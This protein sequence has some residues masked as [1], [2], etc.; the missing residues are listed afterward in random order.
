[1]FPG[2]D[3]VYFARRAG[4]AHAAKIAAV[5]G[6]ARLAHAQLEMAYTALVAAHEADLPA[7]AAGCDALATWDDE[8][9]AVR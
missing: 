1:M 5:D 9:G 8:G 7:P 2:S 3:A 4:E 6:G